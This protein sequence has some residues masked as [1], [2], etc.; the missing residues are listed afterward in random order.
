VSTSRAIA[1]AHCLLIAAGAAFGC[2]RPPTSQPSGSPAVVVL[3]AASAHEALAAIAVGY[4]ART[5]VAVKISPGASSTLATQ[6]AN[7]APADVF[8]SASDEWVEFLVKKDLVRERRP[9]LRNR[10]VLITPRGN[11]AGVRGPSD[12]TSE[13]VGRVALAGENVPAGRYAEQALRRAGVFEQLHERLARGQNVR[14]VLGYVERGEAQAGVVY[15]TDARLAPAVE[16]VHAFDPADHEP[17]LYPAALLRS[18]PA[19]A[20]AAAFF[21]HLAEAESAA[22]FEAHGFIPVVRGPP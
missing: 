9:L 14:F 7:G 2:A 22:I 15:A 8:V 13:R 1:L 20:S 11:P 3:A 12:L 4:T 18:A 10:L 16:V 21:E 6:I 17:I 19:G 5:G